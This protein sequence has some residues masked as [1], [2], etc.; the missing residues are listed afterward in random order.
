MKSLSGMTIQQRLTLSTFASFPRRLA[1]WPQNVST[2]NNKSR[3]EFSKF[4]GRRTLKN[5][6]Q[7]CWPKA[8]I[9]RIFVKS[10]GFFKVRFLSSYW[11]TRS[12]QPR[13]IEEGCESP[14]AIWQLCV[15]LFAQQ[16]SLF[17]LCCRVEWTRLEFCFS[18][19][20][21]T[22]S[23]PKKWLRTAT[24]RTCFQKFRALF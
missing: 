5:Y 1:T 10:L 6:E 24:Q 14:S 19:Q 11:R 16:F 7:I 22:R 2:S 23:L 9:R 12:E 4:S 13:S 3:M 18:T 15:P 21:C 8:F 20:C 17:P